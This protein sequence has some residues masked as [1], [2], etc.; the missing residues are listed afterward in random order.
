MMN[1]GEG[2]EL[3]VVVFSNWAQKL[4]FSLEILMKYPNWNILMTVNYFVTE[5][6]SLF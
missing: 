4:T 5:E 2:S 6:I 1:D 3:W